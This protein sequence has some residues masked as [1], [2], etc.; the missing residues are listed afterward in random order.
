MK[1]IS[2]ELDLADAGEMGLL[3]KSWK[4]E[5]LSGGEYSKGVCFAMVENAVDRV[6]SRGGE[7]RCIRNGERL[8]QILGFAVIES[9]VVHFVYVKRWLR[10]QGLG[11]KLVNGCRYATYWSEAAQ[12][13]FD[14]LK[15]VRVD[16]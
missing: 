7:F 5:K 3:M 9:D 10:K 13:F 15:L 11:R 16:L 12:P 14:K 4:G 2:D 8:S 6:R 1:I